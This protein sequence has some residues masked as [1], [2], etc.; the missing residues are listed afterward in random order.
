MKKPVSVVYG[1]DEAP[2]PAVTVVSALQQV[3]LMSVNLIYPVLVSREAGGTA[4]VVS[5]VVGVS[6]VALAV[7]TA[8]QSLP[9]G[10]VG[11]G[12][13]CQPVPSSATTRPRFL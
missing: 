8:L 3:A 2:P 10:P 4:E 11:S 5:E 1:V 6:M 9:R 13:L 12:F 7:G